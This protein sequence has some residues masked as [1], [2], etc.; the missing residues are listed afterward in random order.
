MRDVRK[1]D[2]PRPCGHSIRFR[3][4]VLQG[5]RFFAFAP[6]LP[7]LPMKWSSWETKAQRRIRAP[8]LRR[9][10]RLCSPSHADP[11][12]RPSQDK[13]K[14]FD[15]PTNL[16]KPNLAASGEE[17]SATAQALLD[18][19]ASRPEYY[20]NVSGVLLGTTLSVIVLSATMIALESIPLVP[21]AL[22]MVGLIYIFWF[23][24]KF[25]F[26]STERQRLGVEIDEFVGGVRGS[27]PSPTISNTEAVGELGE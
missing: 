19:L 7:S 24:N 12:S 18:D 14:V 26:S 17:A 2:P 11:E 6:P 22:R 21:D 10:P 9:G 8:A 20:L 13:S 15:L 23:L 3:A 27:V 25:L 4:S 5:Q 16:P 1:R